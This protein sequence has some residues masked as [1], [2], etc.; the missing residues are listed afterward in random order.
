VALRLLEVA[1][2]FDAEGALLVYSD[3]PAL[4]GALC[5][6]GSRVR[7]MCSTDPRRQG[8]MPGLVSFLRLLGVDVVDLHWR[9]WTAASVDLVHA[10]GLVAFRWD[11]QYDAACDHLNA[12]GVD[13][14]YG[15]RPDRLVGRVRAPARAVHRGG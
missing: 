4:R 5:A 11:V 8:G 7:L 6:R 1:E 12:L 15:D 2:A 9:P 3:D 14:L 13:A 10:A